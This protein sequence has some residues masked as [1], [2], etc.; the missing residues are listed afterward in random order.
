MQIKNPQFIFQD[1]DFVIIFYVFK[2]KVMI[3]F[4]KKQKNK[5]FICFDSIPYRMEKKENGN[6]AFI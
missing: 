1:Y 4:E 2:V 5:L 3:S 6:G